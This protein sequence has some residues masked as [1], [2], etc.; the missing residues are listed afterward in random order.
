MSELTVTLEKQ[1]EAHG[2]TIKDLKFREPTGADIEEC[3]IPVNF[4]YNMDKQSIEFDVDGKAMTQMMSRLA[5]VPTSTIRMLTASDWVSCSFALQR[6][7][8]PR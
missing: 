6:F 4:R 7:F 2:E 1:V 3:G 8:Q 5:S